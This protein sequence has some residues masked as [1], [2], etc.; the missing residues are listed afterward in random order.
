[1]F[2][3]FWAPKRGKKIKGATH[4]DDGDPSDKYTSEE[5]KKRRELMGSRGDVDDAS[6]S[7][8]DRVKKQFEQQDEMLD[9]VSSS[10]ANM[11]NMAN[12]MGTEMDKQD[13]DLDSLTGDV[14]E[15]NNRLKQDNKRGAKLL[16]KK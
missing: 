10:L 6:L 9:D 7:K 3:C 16:G 11:K 8:M 14:D 13:K 2:S 4:N 1:M 15:L 5:A 12:D